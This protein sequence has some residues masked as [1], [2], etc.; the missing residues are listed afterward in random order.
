MTPAEL[1]ELRDKLRQAENLVATV[2]DAFAR[3]SR[4]GGARLL[5]ECVLA[6]Q[7]EIEQAEKE[8]AGQ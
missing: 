1:A 5:N 2:R 4:V 6:L 7:D 3:D 8:L